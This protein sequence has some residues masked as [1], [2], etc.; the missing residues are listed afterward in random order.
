LNFASTKAPSKAFFPIFQDIHPL[1]S[2]PIKQCNPK[3]VLHNRRRFR[4]MLW[5]VLTEVLSQ[6]LTISSSSGKY[7]QISIIVVQILRHKFSLK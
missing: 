7:E 1:F 5:K 3:N 6:A 4:L 2:L